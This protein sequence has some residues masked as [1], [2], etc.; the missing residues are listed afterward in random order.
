MSAAG[1]IDCAVGSAMSLVDSSLEVA[2]A[3]AELLPWNIAAALTNIEQKQQPDR[4]KKIN[5]PDRTPTYA[6]AYAEVHRD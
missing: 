2:N 4:I 1:K 6:T 5:P 3:I